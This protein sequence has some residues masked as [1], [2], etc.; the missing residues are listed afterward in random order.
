MIFIAIVAFLLSA[1][2]YIGFL[3]YVARIP[4]TVAPFLYTC[5]VVLCLYAFGLFGQLPHGATACLVLGLLAGIFAVWH[6]RRDSNISNSKFA[7]VDTLYLIPF[8]VFFFAVPYDYVFT[9]WDEF[10]HW[11]PSIKLMFE[12]NSLFQSDS[13]IAF[14]W[15]P[16]GQQLFQY[17]IVYFLGWSEAKVLYAQIFLILAAL[18]ATVG[19][20]IKRESPVGGVAFITSCILVYLFKFDLAHILVDPLLAV[21]FTATVALAWYA[22]NR[23][24][25][26]IMLSITIA[27]LVLIK[28]IGLI[29][30]LIAVAIY[31]TSVWFS[32]QEETGHRGTSG[33]PILLLRLSQFTLPLLA[34]IA[35]SQSWS[36]YVA[37][38]GAVQDLTLPSFRDLFEAP[39]LER[40]QA[41][42]M[43]FLDR[44]LSIKFLGPFAGFAALSAIAV[45]LNPPV[46]QKKASVQ[47]A[48]LF[49]SAIGYIGF[50]FISYLLFFTEY[51][52][53]RLASFPR[54]NKT[55]L[56]AW[57]LIVNALLLSY[58]QSK[59]LKAQYW[60]AGITFGLM[61]AIA[62]SR[63]FANVQSLGGSPN[64][65]QTRLDIEQLSSVFRA[66]AAPDEKVYFISQNSSGY[67][68]LVF[69]Y[70]ML[71]SRSSDSCWSIG[72]SYNKA[73]IWTCNIALS[74]A[75]E[76]YSY[77][78]IFN[79]D[80][81][82]WSSNYW[83]LSKAADGEPCQTLRVT[84]IGTNV[85]CLDR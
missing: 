72:D 79:A 64:L 30:A 33:R 2:G 39:L 56:L 19:S 71:P 8:A 44:I 80:Q 69:A 62:P 85:E 48:I 75:L 22:S 31:W 11:G 20:F 15:Y 58:A 83:L 34:L 73:D 3:H 57:A 40:T 37:S 1:V 42:A 38:I 67:H 43:A 63:F 5:I 17:Y 82:F 47:L 77:L 53:M 55:Y 50:L 28:Q 59:S 14:K 49:V 68:K 26:A 18:L 65:V 51:E 60:T 21:H 41:T 16:P 76:G 12:T 45:K 70:L 23:L 4:L 46:G 78:A 36:W 13:P 9:E 84:S 74:A 81:N 52:G 66:K 10:S 32:D 54:Y 35:A 6:S 7:L 61:L 29:F 25:S 24:G 27:V